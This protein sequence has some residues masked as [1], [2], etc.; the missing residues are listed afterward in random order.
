MRDDGFGFPHVAA[1]SWVLLGKEKIG[2]VVFRAEQ[3]ADTSKYIRGEAAFTNGNPH[4]ERAQ[5]CACRVVSGQSKAFQADPKIPAPEI[6]HIAAA[7]P[8]M[9]AQ[10]TM[11]GIADKHRLS[12]LVK[13]P[14][15]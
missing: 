13:L 1:G 9:V 6:F 14:V 11:V 10:T 8:G 2:M 12:R 7:A 4:S 3:P 5:D 15:Y